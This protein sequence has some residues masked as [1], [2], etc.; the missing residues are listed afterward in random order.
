M[1]V[2]VELERL[3]ANNLEKHII[4]SI[5][6]WQ[7]FDSWKRLGIATM[8]ELKDYIKEEVQS[9]CRNN[10]KSNKDGIV[11]KYFDYLAEA[12]YEKVEVI[13]ND[14]YKVLVKI[15]QYEESETISQ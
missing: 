12:G 6:D 11:V 3:G 10:P 9:F 7:K 5:E 2:K 1:K 15:I 14:S 13:R 8:E 4:S